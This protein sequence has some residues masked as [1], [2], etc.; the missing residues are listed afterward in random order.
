MK[1][2]AEV[3]AGVFIAVI[4]A[5]FAIGWIQ[6]RRAAQGEARSRQIEIRSRQTLKALTPQAVIARCGKPAE[7]FPGLNPASGRWDLRYAKSDDE[8]VSISF[9]KFGDTWQYMLM[10]RIG[11]PEFTT[12][13]E[14]LAALPCLAP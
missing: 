10:E 9:F 6:Q 8:T 2:V 4:G 11:G 13:A 5:Y 1:R 7:Q 12:A 3:A 14:E